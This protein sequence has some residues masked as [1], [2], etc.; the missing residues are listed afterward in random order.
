MRRPRAP[1]VLVTAEDAEAYCDWA[2]GRLPSPL[3]WE[4]A[5]GGSDGRRFPWGNQPPRPELARYGTGD[6]LAALDVFRE[7]QD[8]GGRP[9]G[10]S[11]FGVLDMAGNVAEWSTHPEGR[12]HGGSYFTSASE[13]AI[14]S[15]KGWARDT[16]GPALGFRC[17]MDDPG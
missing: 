16:P 11:P 8:V 10:M 9:E 6:P 4:W 2:G 14:A 15:F 13:V 7:I 1:V 12:A 17:A 3:E 5:A